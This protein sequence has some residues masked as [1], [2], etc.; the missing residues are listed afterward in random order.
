MCNEREA[1]DLFV[2]NEHRHTSEK[3]SRRELQKPAFVVQRYAKQNVL[4]LGDIGHFTQLLLD[5]YGPMHL[6]GP[7][8]LCH[9]AGVTPELRQKD[10]H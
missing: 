2:R 4:R 9:R 10:Q 3:D 5:F 1:I 8:D 7:F 6:A